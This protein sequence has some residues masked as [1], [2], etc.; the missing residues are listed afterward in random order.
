M[1]AFRG[2]AGDNRPNL[3]VDPMKVKGSALR[4]TMNYLREHFTP[5]QVNRV[6]A[7]L[8]PARRD[9]LEKPILISTWYEAEVLFTLMNAMTKELSQPPE[10]LFHRL[11]RQSCDDGL[12]TVYRIFFKIGTP[13]YMLKFTSQVWRNYYDQGKFSVVSGSANHAHLRLEGISFPDAGMCIRLTGWLERAL[14]LSA[15]K[16]IRMAHSSC[17]FS[18]APECEWK[19]SWE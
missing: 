8:P 10:V 9:T 2:M 4:S 5:E 17:K 13:S 19:G 1:L 16:N 12:N 3:G 15:A 14:E 18:G 7:V 6:I 11:G